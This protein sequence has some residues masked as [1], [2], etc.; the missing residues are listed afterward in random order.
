[1]W[2]E[3]VG[4]WEMRG[5]VLKAHGRAPS[6]VR[7]GLKGSKDRRTARSGKCD[8]GKTTAITKKEESREKEGEKH[9]RPGRAESMK[10]G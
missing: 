9:E 6:R 4:R 8:L 3:I 5:L 2:G 7:K 10:A 1:V